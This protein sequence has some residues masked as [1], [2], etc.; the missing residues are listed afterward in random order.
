MENWQDAWHWLVRGI[1]ALIGVIASL[2]IVAPAGTKNAMYRAWVGVSMGVI[3]APVVPQ[4]PWMAW[5]AGISVEHILARAAFA[6]FATWFALEFIARML[7]ST[8]WLVRLA[9]EIL[10][11]RSGGRDK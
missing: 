9:Q 6:G 10:R 5:L 8:D 7:S 3:F 1:G 4:L 2:I 11:L